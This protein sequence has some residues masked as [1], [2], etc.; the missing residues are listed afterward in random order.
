[1]GGALSVPS[2]YSKHTYKEMNMNTARR[3]FFLFLCFIVVPNIFS[4]D[5]HGDTIIGRWRMVSE[6]SEIKSSIFSYIAIVRDQKYD[7][8]YQMIP[9]TLDDGIG[10]RGSI[11]LFYDPRRKEYLFY[12][13]GYLGPGVVYGNITLKSDK[14]MVMELHLGGVD[15]TEFKISTRVYEKESDTVPTDIHVWP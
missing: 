9:G 15:D 4:F 12:K 13:I 14:E 11:F 5:L 8:H 10:G 7:G 1:M 6:K 3:T 2:T